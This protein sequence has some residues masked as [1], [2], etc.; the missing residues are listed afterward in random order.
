MTSLRHHTG[1]CHCGRVRFEV[2]LDTD[3]A[4]TCNCSICH[5]LGYVMQ[6]VPASRFVLLAGDDAQDDY[7]F[8]SETMHHLFCRTC[9]VH[10]YG[11]FA[12]DGGEMRLVNLRCVDGVDLDTLTI[13]TFDGR[14]Y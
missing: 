14:S 9:G 6:S 7:R 3:R 2:D 13:E 1:S 10:A 5:R 4:A 12:R 8:G 11:T